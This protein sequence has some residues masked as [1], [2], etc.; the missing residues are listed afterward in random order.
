MAA[1][2]ES[3][4]FALPPLQY[5]HGDVLIKLGHEKSDWLVVHSKNLSDSSPNLRATLSSRWAATIGIEKIKHPRTGEEVSVKTMAL[6]YAEGAY[7]LEGKEVLPDL[8]LDAQVFQDTVWSRGKGWPRMGADVFG[9]RSVLDMTKRAFRVLVATMHGI[10]LTAEQVA[11]QP[12]HD[13]SE[14]R[15]EDIGASTWV[16]EILFP[17]VV[18]VCAIA[19]F[20]DCL[21]TVGPAMMAILHSAPRYWQAVAYYPL[22]HMM[23]AVKLKNREVF[24]DA[25]RHAM[26]QAYHEDNDEVTWDAIVAITGQAAHFNPVYYKLQFMRMKVSAANLKMDLHRLQTGAGQRQQTRRPQGYVWSIFGMAIAGP[27]YDAK[28]DSKEHYSS[29]ARSI[30]GDW[31]AQHLYVQHPRLS[32]RRYRSE[33]PNVHPLGPHDAPAL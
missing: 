30:F 1:S 17:Q 20:L 12:D 8:R 29:I 6:K 21:S 15:K 5:D 27:G 10:N 3:D 22:K 31:L 19:E 4:R 7:F 16:N 26:A 13:D 18:T 14:H 2:N 9:H 11:G 24:H 32:P 28:L 33:E 23:I 25:Y